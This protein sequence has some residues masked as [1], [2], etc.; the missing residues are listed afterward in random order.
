MPCVSATPTIS[1]RNQNDTESHNL[2]TNHIGS[3]KLE[4]WGVVES[5]WHE[6]DSSQEW[7]L[8][9][10]YIVCHRTGKSARCRFGWKATRASQMINAVAFPTQSPG[11]RL[12]ILQW[13][14]GAADLQYADLTGADLDNAELR[15]INWHGVAG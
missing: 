10:P 2:H 4:V 12:P 11:F 9:V 3:G 13:P 14:L 7:S 8:I 1:M 5:R 15:R 6:T